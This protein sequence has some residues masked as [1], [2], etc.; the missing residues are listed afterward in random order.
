MLSPIWAVRYVLDGRPIDELKER[1]L[2]VEVFHKPP[3]YDTA[4]DNIVRVTANEVRKRLA[5]YYGNDH[6]SEGLT[7]QLQSGSY[8]ASFLWKEDSPTA[9]RAI[10]S[11]APETPTPS[12]SEERRVGEEC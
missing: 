8:A 6:R 4:Q 5:Q 10:T 11:I 1:T 3:S 12:R 9:V 2:G 7:I